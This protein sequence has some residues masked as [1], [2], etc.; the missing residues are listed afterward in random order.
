MVSRSSDDPF[1]FS[2]DKFKKALS[3][4]VPR[5]D[6]EDCFENSTYR[7]SP[8]NCIILDAP[9]R[10]HKAWIESRYLSHLHGSARSLLHR[11]AVI[12]VLHRTDRTR[13]TRLPSSRFESSARE[14]IERNA[15]ILRGEAFAGSKNRIPAGSAQE[16]GRE[17][18][19]VPAGTPVNPEFALDTLSLGPGNLFAV[20]ACLEAFKA[21]RWHYN[22]LVLYGES[23]SGKSHLL[24]G[25]HSELQDHCG[26]SSVYFSCSDFMRFCS[27]QLGD[28]SAPGGFETSVKSLLRAIEPAE[29][30]FIDDVQRLRGDRILCDALARVLDRF[31]AEGKQMVMSLDC[32]P[33]Q[34]RFGREPFHSGKEDG[35]DGSE[36]NGGDP[37]L[38]RIRSGLVLE[39]ERPGLPMLVEILKRKLSA[40]DV[41]VSSE[42]AE[43]LARGTEGD[44]RELDGLVNR[45][46]LDIETNRNR[47]GAPRAGKFGR[48]QRTKRR[49]TV[50][51]NLDLPE[52]LEHV[53]A[54]FSKTPSDL[55]S[56]SRKKTTSLARQVAMYLARELTEMSYQRIGKYFGGK[57]HA[58]VL[59]S[60][61]RI[62]DRIKKDQVLARDLDTLV[63]VIHR[64]HKE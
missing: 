41:K 12:E 28:M 1:A 39:I 63:G 57:H 58:T 51:T 11:D 24:Q 15:E 33:R 45:L 8:P 43:R 32:D 38:A 20:L 27:A 50:P 36:E 61:G 4:R 25:F 19:S 35:P 5:E 26:R 6:F 37:I 44:P 18:D 47:A 31:M 62:R 53:A 10:I 9:S 3:E 46:R 34:V 55:R 29:I 2:A 52:I 14:T 42:L 22:P 7:F 56:P 23:G 54:Y 59:Y 17:S 60:V 40:V 49:L 13:P 21:R 48:S 16:R 30:L 64:S